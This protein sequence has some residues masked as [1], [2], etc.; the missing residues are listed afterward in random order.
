MGLVDFAPTVVRS[1]SELGDVPDEAPLKLAGRVVG[2]R[3]GA[4]IVADAWSHCLV[5]L[6]ELEPPGGDLSDSNEPSS[7]PEG[8]WLVAFG[9]LRGGTLFASSYETFAG[10]PPTATSEHGR[11]A[12]S[13]RARALRA[14]ATATR[15]IREYFRQEGFVE[16]ETPSLVPCPGLDT[17]V[18]S[19]GSVTRSDGAVD[20]LITSP[21][22]HLKRLVVGGMPRVYEIA[23]CFRDEELG[24]HHEPEFTLVEWYRAFAGPSEVL[25]DT[26][27][28]VA[29]TVTALRGRP[30]LSLPIAAVPNSTSTG[31]PGTSGPN[32]GAP[33]TG[34][35]NTGTPSTGTPSTAR[36][37]IDVTPPFE[38]LTVRQAF[39]KYAR[40]RDA[41]ALARDDETRYY[42]I[43]VGEVEPA[44]REER[45]PVFL[46][47]YPLSQASLARVSAEDPTVAERFELYVAGLELCN[48][49]AELT[50]PVEQRRRF[51]VERERRRRAGEPCYP[52][53]ERFLAA[54]VEGMPPTTGNA[55]GLDRLVLL[56]TGV[57]ELGLVQAFP[58][59]DR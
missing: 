23:R 24:V 41:V 6:P 26:E 12:F 32:T 30:E 43:L 11:L 40:V 46:T 4:L 8:A 5:R 21:E 51:E 58:A 36:R 37:T 19:L 56:A 16:V 25:A 9:T 55:L 54:L 49:F 7:V 50:D 28:L 57:S 15:V 18:H 14:R 22:L 33:N 1:P 13:G 39:E 38:R 47:H 44:L 3:D 20:W 34:T 31:T 29:R 10:R 35:P 17:H 42:E 2:H 48:G 59:A 53:D 52:L 27:Q 45:R